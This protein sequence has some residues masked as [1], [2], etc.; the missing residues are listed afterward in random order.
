[1][2]STAVFVDLARAAF[3][4][5]IL[6][7]PHVCSSCLFLM[8]VPHVCSIPPVTHAIFRSPNR[9]SGTS[10]CQDLKQRPLYFKTVRDNPSLFAHF[11]RP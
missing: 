4:T 10:Q 6:S 3:G 2:P 1:M 7:V 8:S 9:S 5:L 11:I